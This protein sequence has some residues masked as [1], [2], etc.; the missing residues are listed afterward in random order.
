MTKNTKTLVLAPSNKKSLL[1]DKRGIEF[2]QFLVLCAIAVTCIAGFMAMRDK[3]KE[4]AGEQTET[5][6]GIESSTGG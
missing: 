3:V 6:G 1:K 2:V 4:K 5:I